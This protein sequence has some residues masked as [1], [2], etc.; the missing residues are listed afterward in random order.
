[1]KQF[2]IK[3]LSFLFFSIVI[4]VFCINVINS[5]IRDNAKFKI[6]Q[7][8]KHVV[9]G[10]SHPECA[11]NDSLISDFK[12]LSRSAE[13]YFF[14]YPKVKNIIKQNPNIETVFIEFTN[15]YLD[16][17][18]EELIWD[19]R[20][21]ASTYA[22]YSSFLS[23]VENFKLLTNNFLAFSNSFSISLRKNVKRIYEHNYDYSWYLGGYRYTVI[24]KADSLVRNSIN[25]S[26]ESHKTMSEI[27]EY[28]ILYLEKIV[29]FCLE[30]NKKVVLIRSPQHNK[31]PLLENEK[32]FSELLR[33]RFSNVDFLDFNN[34]PLEI[35]DYYD[36]N[37][38][39][40]YGARKFSIWFNTLLKNGLL[41]NADKQNYVNEQM[42]IYARN[43]KKSVL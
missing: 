11:L 9:F 34:F 7:N 30:K 16:K 33:S 40:Y 14:T 35:S 31:Y 42:A 19:S 3:I 15:N 43:K 38:L 28:N 6:D 37:H 24:N 25:I 26:E 4:L 32:L 21:L 23:S 8:I 29:S 17:R 27:S 13:I 36:L 22:V 41:E 12:N 1:M 39:N 5:T 10:H 20:F 2:I 18:A